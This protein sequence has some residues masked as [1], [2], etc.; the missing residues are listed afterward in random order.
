MTYTQAQE[1]YAF[2]GKE[3]R[4]NID[5]DKT[6]RYSLIHTRRGFALIDHNSGG[7]ENLFG[8]ENDFEQATMVANRAD[9]VC[10][11]NVKEMLKL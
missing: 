1:L 9:V 11:T 3:P 4:Y 5:M 6:I 10:S 7:G 8:G 2:S